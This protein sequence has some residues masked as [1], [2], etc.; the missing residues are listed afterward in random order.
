[1]FISNNFWILNFKII[2][3]QLNR[4]VDLIIGGPPCQGFSISG[5]R[6]PNDPRNKLYI[7]FVEAVKYFKP[8]AF[9]MENVPNLASMQKGLILNSI[10]NLSLMNAVKIPR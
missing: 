2:K 10:L 8:E 3:N 1:M 7:A 5:K 6:N 9:V 4:K